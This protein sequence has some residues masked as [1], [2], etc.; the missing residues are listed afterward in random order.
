MAITRTEFSLRAFSLS[1]AVWYG[2]VL[3]GWALFGVA[4]YQVAMTPSVEMI[5]PLAMTA[6]LLVT[7]ELLPLVQGRGRAPQGG[8]GVVVIHDTSQDHTD[9]VARELG[10]ASPFQ[11]R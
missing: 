9:G 2:T 3:S 11:V 7:L 1:S 4:G 5:A 6:I 8:V 10:A